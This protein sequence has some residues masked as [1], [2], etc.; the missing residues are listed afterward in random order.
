MPFPAVVVYITLFSFIIVLILFILWKGYTMKFLIS[1]NHIEIHG[2]YRKQI[3]ALSEIDTIKKIP[4]PFGFRLVGASLLG[5]RYYF[6]GIG[7]A[8]V[9]MNNF[10]N[11]VLLTTKH[12]FNYVI[13]PDDPLKFID[14]VKN[15][16]L[17]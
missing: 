16:T 13:T 5:G 10:V 8:S 15:N 3:I 6:P 14:V 11:G 4:I 9:T 2:L 17:K 7:N 12:G 1:D